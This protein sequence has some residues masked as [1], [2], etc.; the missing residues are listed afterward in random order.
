MSSLNNF[1]VIIGGTQGDTGSVNALL[2]PKLQ[3]RFRV[4]VETF[5]A[6]ISKRQEFTK[7]VI[8]V[9]KPSVSFEKIT[10]DMYNSRVYLAG[11]HNWEPITINLLDDA[12]KNIQQLVGEQ[13][14]KQFDFYEQS[15]AAAGGDYKFT[16]IINVLD[17]G[18]G[19][20]DSAYHKP[21]EL[22]AFTLMGCWIES[23]SYNSLNYAE[24]GPQ[25]ITLTICYD[26]AVQTDEKRKGAG[27]GAAFS[28]AI[29]SFS[30]STLST[31]AGA[32]ELPPQDAADPIVIPGTTG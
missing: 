10:L 20:G 16:T 26:N 31:G 11:K 23:A 12:D 6:T 4:I 13:L 5:G 29:N 9:Q 25:T 2:M 22:E 15:S 24:S 14:Q 28:S 7:Q 1:G 17:G 32:P 3:Y 21:N 8:D 19:N 30:G 27:I 18:K